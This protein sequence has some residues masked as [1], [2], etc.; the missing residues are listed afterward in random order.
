MP[1]VL[2][3]GRPGRDADS[4]ADEDGDLVLEDVFC[5]RAV[6][7]VD[8]QGREA[9]TVH[10]RHFVHAVGID[11][12]VELSLGRAGADAVGELLGEVADLPDV[13]GDVV[14]VGA[15]GD[16][17]GVPLV[18]GDLRHLQKE[19][20]AG[21]VLEG[22]LVELDLDHV[23]RVAHHARDLGF[24]DGADFAVQALQKVE[25][26]RPE[27]PAPAE[28]ADAVL[29]VLLAGE[30]REAVGGVAHEAADGVGVQG[31]EEGDEE[32]VGVPEGFEGLL[33]DAVVGGRVHQEHAE[34]HHMAGD[35]AGL[36]VVNLDCRYGA[37]LGLL[38]VEETVAGLV[39]VTGVLGL[40]SDTHLT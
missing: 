28:V 8:A 38:D 13:D 34:E 6:G 9:V 21:L 32:V 36:G 5:G 33:A 7:P 35:T 37:N 29:P 11:A 22:R 27:L 14:V 1:D 16:G 2:E 19:P 40:L 30:G 15:R 23:V 18:L 25:A 26:A 3:D 31:Q 4:R 10:E 12:V 20:L 17:E 24:A 39:M